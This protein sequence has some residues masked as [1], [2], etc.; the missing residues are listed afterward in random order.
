M[1]EDSTFF[2][3]ILLRYLGQVCLLLVLVLQVSLEIPSAFPELEPG[4]PVDPVVPGVA[5]LQ[6]FSSG[7]EFESACLSCHVSLQRCKSFCAL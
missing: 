1:N 4:F 7:F 3:P 6:V 2:Y 5:V